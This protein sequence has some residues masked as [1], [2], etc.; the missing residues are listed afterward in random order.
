M[1]LTRVSSLLLVCALNASPAA[2][3]TPPAG[4]QTPPAPTGPP[5]LWE[6]KAELSL[7]ATGGNS[8]TQTIGAG[9]SL[10]WRPAPW[11]TEAK[12]AF[13]RSEANEVVTAESLAADFR[14]ARALTPRVDAFG[15]LGYLSNEFA[16]VDARTSVDGGIAYK[17]LTGPVHTLRVDAGLGYSDEARTTGEDLS[18]VLANFGSAYK[19]QL[20]P[21]ADI[22]ESA[23]FTLS[24]EDAADRRFSNTFALTA[25][26]TRLFSLKLSHELKFV[27][28]PV[29]T[30][31]KTDT[32]LSVAL[33]ASF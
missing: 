17:L 14:Q 6:R 2:A 7:V 20:S 10:V 26:L 23:L 19:W 4:A 3:Q 25:A 27:N 15:R 33:V 30:F 5:P 28:A 24:L 11:T 1:W 21:T 32:Q 16:G 29:P 31:E 8:D 22:T 18:F 9:A 12:I 13:V